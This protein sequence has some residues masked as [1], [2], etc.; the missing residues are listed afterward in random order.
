M[1]IERLGQGAL[2]LKKLWQQNPNMNIDNPTTI[3]NNMNPQRDQKTNVVPSEPDPLDMAG[4]NGNPA[5]NNPTPPSNSPQV[6][7]SYLHV[8]GEL[9]EWLEKKIYGTDE[10]EEE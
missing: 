2:N 9:P 10:Q 5:N 6:R 3:P 1:K 8:F 7:N 4:V